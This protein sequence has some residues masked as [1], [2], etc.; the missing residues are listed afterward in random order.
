M[1]LYTFN[2]ND[3]V[4]L[5]PC[6][7][8][9]RLGPTSSQCNT[10]YSSAPFTPTNSAHFSVNNGIQLWTVPVSGT[11]RIKALGARG[12]RVYNY[13]QTNPYAYYPSHGTGANWRDPYNNGTV[14]GTAGFGA[15]TEG[16]FT[17]TQ[18]D[19]IAVLVGQ[20]GG[21]VN[22]DNWVKSGGGGGASWVCNEARTT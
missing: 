8:S 20:H 17:F 12:G 1:S 15:W 16:E 4:T 22:Y 5:T 14:K 6:N 13:T 10:E 3:S 9:G 7:A 18:G 11:Y 2:V 19:K 21:D